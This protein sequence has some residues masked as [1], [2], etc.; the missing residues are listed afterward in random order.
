MNTTEELQFISQLFAQYAISTHGILIPN[1]FLQLS[2]CAM[3]QLNTTGRS[4]VV[5]NLVKCIGTM[6]PGEESSRLPVDR[7]PMGL[8]EYCVNFFSSSN[9]Q[10]VASILQL[11]Q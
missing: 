5:Y 3:K 4:N 10:Q 11:I 8:L 9:L 1:D 6:R 7:M 2:L